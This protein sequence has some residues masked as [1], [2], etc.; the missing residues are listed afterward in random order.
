MQSLD[1]SG[2]SPPEI[3]TVHE[4]VSQ[5]RENLESEFSA[6]WVTGEISNLKTPHSG[7]T[8]FT[9]K[10][11]DAQIQA[12][13][14]KFKKRYIRFEPEDGMQVLCKGIVTVY[15]V[16]GT[17]QINVEYMEPVGLGAL[18]LA[19]EQIKERLDKE[20]LFDQAHK[21]ELPHVPQ[22]IGVITSPTGAAIQ[23]ILK[24]ITRRFANVEIL[25]VPVRVQG[26]SAASEIVEALELLNRRKDRDVIILARGGGSLEDLWPF[27]EESVARAMFASSIP[28]ISA[29]G[30]ET[31]FTIAD[32]VADFR[33]PTPSAAAERV[34]RN[35]AD[36]QEKLDALARRLR[37]QS[38][39]LLERKKS[40]LEILYRRLVSPEQKI[41]RAQ[42]HL[43][44]LMEGL[45][46]SIRY[47]IESLKGRL[48]NQHSSLRLLSPVEKIGRLG[49]RLATMQNKLRREADILLKSRRERYGALQRRLYSLSPLSVLER[50]YSIVTKVPEGAIVRDSR[51]LLH[52]DRLKIQFHHGRTECIVDKTEES[53][54]P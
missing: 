1:G 32:F 10:D 27:N 22:R 50:G 25:I 17:V 15:E 14:F 29:V 35:K 6:I 53:E 37:G 41:G 11:K 26:D 18:H 51:S 33:A 9:L 4:L 36:I 47:R 21:K 34:V 13:F 43:D 19:F 42:Q 54:H 20:G 39:Y 2:H 31:D 23:D 28:V 7:H 5:I 49:E 24:I 45:E 3:L 46:R 48:L 38:R 12:V 40:E 16:R 8:Y 44:E 52:K 30:H